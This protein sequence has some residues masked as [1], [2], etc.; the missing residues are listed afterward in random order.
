[1]RCDYRKRLLN[2]HR[3]NNAKSSIEMINHKQ[4]YD[5]YAKNIARH[6]TVWAEENLAETQ[7]NQSASVSFLNLKCGKEQLLGNRL[8]FI[9]FP[10]AR[11]NFNLHQMQ[12][13]THTPIWIYH[14]ANSKC[15]QW[16]VVIRF[17]D[18]NY[19][20]VLEIGKNCRNIICE[21]GF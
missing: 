11:A 14:E 21:C 16:M 12:A 7:L 2:Y 13:H 9:N 20:R 15:C 8:I 5:F 1:M 19:L 17:D 4:V 18:T 6:S 10:F 3:N